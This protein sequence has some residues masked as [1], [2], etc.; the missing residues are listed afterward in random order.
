[1]SIKSVATE[2]LQ[3]VV[4]N[5][6]VLAHKLFQPKKEGW[7]RLMR[8]ALGMSGAQLARRMGV[9]R[10]LISNTEKAEMEGRITINKMQE[11]ADAMECQF[12]YSM[13]PN[14]KIRNIVIKRAEEKARAIVSRTNE[15]MALEAQSLTDEQIRSEVDRLAEQMLSGK[16]SVLW[17]D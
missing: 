4:D 17:N 6:A 3:N 8:Q 10:G 9:S 5:N 11:Y 13:V 12:V 1:M 2:Q 15:H 16:T 7:I 14:D